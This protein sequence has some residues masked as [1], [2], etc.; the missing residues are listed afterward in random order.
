MGCTVAR[1][2]SGGR[3]ATKLN[4]LLPTDAP[5]SIVPRR[6]ER[7]DA[8]VSAGS[9]GITMHQQGPGPPEAPATRLLEVSDF[10]VG[11]AGVRALHGVSLTVPEG[12]IVAVLGHNG[13]G[14]TTLLRAISGTLHLHGGAVEGGS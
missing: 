2:R 12:E 1:G 11:Y 4:N 9:P 7:R 6:E 13:A 3:P 8:G 10:R 14:K 5:P